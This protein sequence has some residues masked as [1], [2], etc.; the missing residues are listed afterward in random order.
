MC[1][2]DSYTPTSLERAAGFVSLVL[3]TTGNGGC[4][5]VSDT[6]QIILAPQPSP[7]ITGSVILC[8]NTSVNYSVPVQAG[9]SY[10]WSATGGVVNG[11]PASNSTNITWSNAASGTVIITETNSYGC[12]ATQTLNVSMVP[13]PNPVITGNNL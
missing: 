7:S 5:A 2:R 13:V 12:S 4:P 6:V 9:N 1:I 10:Y 11:S 3:Q 8:A